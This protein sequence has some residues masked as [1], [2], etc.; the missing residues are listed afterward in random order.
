MKKMKI[1]FQVWGIEGIIHNVILNK[2]IIGK[3]FKYFRRRY[4]FAKKFWHYFEIE[5]NYSV[6]I[7]KEHDL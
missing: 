1:I 5:K 4:R 6:L 3:F 2:I 7:K